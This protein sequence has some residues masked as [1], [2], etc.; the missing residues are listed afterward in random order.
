MLGAGATPTITFQISETPK[1]GSKLQSGD[2]V[3]TN[4][5]LGALTEVSSQ[6]YTAVLTPDE[7]STS[8]ILIMVNENAIRDEVNFGNE[9]ALLNIAVD[10]KYPT[11]TL[12]ADNTTLNASEKSSI[13]ITLSENPKNDLTIDDIA[14]LN[15]TGGTL[16]GT[17]SNFNKTSSQEYTVEFTPPD[18]AEDSATIKV[19]ANTFQDSAGNPNTEGSTQ[20]SF[21]TV[22]PTV[23][24][25][26]SPSTLRRGQTS[27]VTMTLSE[28][29]GNFALEDI[30]FPPEKG[31]LSSFT[32]NGSN[33]K[34]YTAQF[35]PAQDLV[36]DVILTINAGSFDGTTTGN[37]NAA[38]HV[39]IDV[40]TN[41]TTINAGQMINLDDY[42]T[43]SKGWVD[44][45]IPIPT[46]VSQMLFQLYGGTAP[47][48]SGGKGAKIEGTIT[49][50]LTKS[51]M[52]IKLFAGGSSGSGGRGGAAIELQTD[53]SA[54]AIAGGGG[55]F[56]RLSGQGV[57]K[58]GD[59]PSSTGQKSGGSSRNAFG[60]S[61]NNGG[62]PNLTNLAAGGSSVGGGGG[63]GGGAGPGG[64]GSNPYGGGAGAS[65]IGTNVSNS[66]I[67]KRTGSSA[68]GLDPKIMIEM[69]PAKPTI[70]SVSI[71]HSSREVTLAGTGTDTS[72]N[73][74]IQIYSQDETWLGETEDSKTNSNW[75]KKIQFTEDQTDLVIYA[76][77]T[78]TILTHNLQS[79]NSDTQTITVDTTSPSVTI[80]ANPESGLKA[81][82]TAT[83]TFAL[84]EDSADFQKDDITVTGGELGDLVGSG[85]SYTA[86]FTPAS[87][88]TANAT[89]TVQSG[90]FHDAAGNPN[91]ASSRTITGI[92]TKKP[93]VN[94]SANYIT[95]QAGGRSEMTFTFSEV[96]QSFEKNMITITS[97]DITNPEQYLTSPV[98]VSSKTYKATLTPPDNKTTN[99]SLEVQ[100]NKFEGETSRNMNSASSRITISIRTMIP[101][102]HVTSSTNSLK[103]G[104]TA[105]I[106]FALSE[107]ST[108]FQ[109]DDITVTGG[110]LGDLVRS[111][112]NYTATFTPNTDSTV[113]GVIS[114]PSDKFTN[115]E[116]NFNKDGSD[117]NNNVTIAVNTVRPTVTI[118][119]DSNNTNQDKILLSF[120]LDEPT[121]DF[122]AGD[123]NVTPLTGSIVAN[124]F[125]KVSNNTYTAELQFGSEE[126][127][128]VSVNADKFTGETSGN[129]NVQSNSLQITYDKTAPVISNPKNGQTQRYPVGTT[130]ASI[131]SQLESGMKNDENLPL[132]L[133][134]TPSFQ[135][136]TVDE[137]AFSYSVSDA[138]G[139]SSANIVIPVNIVPKTPTLSRS[140]LI[141]SIGNYLSSNSYTITP[142]PEIA[143]EDG[144][145]KGNWGTT[146]KVSATKDGLTSDQGTI[147][148]PA[149][150]FPHSCGDPYIQSANGKI[151]KI[152]DKHGFYRMFQNG[153]IFINT[154]VQYLNVKNELKSFLEMVGYGFNPRDG[155]LPIV[156]G[157]WTKSV[158]IQSEGHSFSYNLFNNKLNKTA[159]Y[160]SIEENGQGRRVAHE[161]SLDDDIQRSIVVSWCHS[162]HGKQEVVLDWYHNPQVQNGV[163]IRSPLIHDKQS[164]GLFIKNYKAK[165][166]EL[167]SLEIGES[168]KLSNKI[169]KAKRNGKKLTHEKPIKSESEDWYVWN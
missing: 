8:S 79:Q 153:D 60:N 113:D 66:S 154:E 96:P 46:G 123:I 120:N 92:N 97:S 135:A 124:S 146:Y 69:G 99:I 36:E 24:M 76:K 25:S 4:G 108:D 101:K 110:E 114:V 89:I 87:D 145:F 82:E 59:A 78:T 20:I 138:A 11:V 95:I 81:D 35:T 168:K 6:K 158:F 18:N 1:S 49:N 133:L 128:T 127:Y 68:N 52:K 85:R 53:N 80:T 139:N 51:N 75:S 129:P 100:G 160:F 23:T 55:G 148:F 70:D 86:T 115:S 61:N 42:N 15:S 56:G 50:L 7:N 33:T 116:G 165:Y 77:Q 21:N 106:T 93:T 131:K 150:V 37:S 105:T 72:S 27:T 98:R 125:E 126:A 109:K 159:N 10:T 22:R 12:T 48:S 169:K 157:Y 107:E 102:I 164:L 118:R 39:T 30:T 140:C 119:C 121:A 41:S 163:S 144:K 28:E 67:V 142:D 71:D 152:P 2:I 90:K 149:E 16:S 63:G 73:S 155:K 13:T 162:V 137:Y 103:F 136:N 31:N 143:L 111:G 134:I 32:H 83:I 29:S 19:V 5:S 9:L 117:D 58:G 64:P 57:W 38:G 112:R 54:V 17:L 147:V 122:Q 88:S 26:A 161:M 130:E 44:Q 84:S 141:V 104:Q 34:I 45:N 91:I 156:E 151:T 65:F 40:R 14:V 3:V 167:D 43:L 47:G 166:M 94:I 74:K 62:T 132:N